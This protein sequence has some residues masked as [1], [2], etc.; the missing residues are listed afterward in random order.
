MRLSKITF[1][2]NETKAEKRN[3]AKKENFSH[4]K[5]D[6]KIVCYLFTEKKLI[7]ELAGYINYYLIETSTSKTIKVN[8]FMILEIR[9]K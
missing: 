7:Y 8:N 4:Y 1:W 5:K 6:Y 9:L 3:H 2:I